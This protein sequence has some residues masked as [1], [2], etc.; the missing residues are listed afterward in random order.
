MLLTSILNEFLSFSILFSL[1][2]FFWLLSFLD[3]I[4]LVSIRIVFV[5]AIMVISMISSLSAMSMSRW[6]IVSSI[7]RSIMVLSVFILFLSY[8]VGSGPCFPVLSSPTVFF[9]W[10]ITGFFKLGMLRLILFLNKFF[11][12]FYVN[13]HSNY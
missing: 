7:S 3:T 5:S 8:W 1:N 12:C 4:R 6:M 2:L 9:L 10:G 13:I 11:E